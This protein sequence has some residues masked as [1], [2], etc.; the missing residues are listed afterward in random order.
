MRCAPNG[1]THPRPPRPLKVAFTGGEERAGEFNGAEWLPQNRRDLIDA[2]FALN[3][4]AAGELDTGGPHVSLDV[5]AGG[6][7]SQNFPLE[8]IKPR[9]T[10]SRP[11]ENNPEYVLTPTLNPVAAGYFPAP[12]TGDSSAD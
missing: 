4:G 8:R 9:G 5:G 7:V 11:G 2:A 10:L 1:P 6:E 12:C 3:E